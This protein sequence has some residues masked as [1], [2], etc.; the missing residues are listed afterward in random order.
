[1]TLFLISLHTLLSFDLHLGRVTIFIIFVLSGHKANLIAQN[2]PVIAGTPMHQR[3]SI[4]CFYKVTLCKYFIS[5]IWFWFIQKAKYLTWFFGI[6]L[7]VFLRCHE[8]SGG[9]WS[10][11][12]L[13]LHSL[14]NGSLKNVLT[15]FVLKVYNS[16]SESSSP[17][18]QYISPSFYSFLGFFRVRN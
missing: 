8:V 11:K 13:H 18:E 1:M 15:F 12:V 9:V 3:E 7:T 17:L 10:V 6:Q 4:K 2:Y 16:G 14:N 5:I